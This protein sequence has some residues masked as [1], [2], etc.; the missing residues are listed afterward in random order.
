MSSASGGFLFKAGGHIWTSHHVI[1]GAQR[2]RVVLFNASKH[3]AEVV[4]VMSA[5]PW[6]CEARGDLESPCSLTSSSCA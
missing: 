6:L 4:R 2:V 3:D 1:A 5:P